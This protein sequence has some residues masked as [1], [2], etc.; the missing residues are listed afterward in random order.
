MS[1]PRK[2]RE[3]IEDLDERRRGGLCP[4][5][6][7]FGVLEDLMGR[8]SNF[9]QHMLASRKEFLTALKSLIEDRIESID[10]EVEKS[11]KKKSKLTKI[12]VEAA[13]D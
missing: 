9:R 5:G 13:E 10:K 2:P 11:S 1:A 8:Q 3:K 4:V 12:K 6:E 7:F